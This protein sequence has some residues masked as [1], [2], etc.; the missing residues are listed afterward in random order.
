MAKTAVCLK[1]LKNQ[2]EKTIALATKMRLIDKSLIISRKTDCLLIPLLHYPTETEIEMLKKETSSKVT[3]SELDSLI[4]EEGVFEEKVQP[5]KTLTQALQD[6][7]PKDLLAILPQAF[8]IVGDIV[9]IDIPP[10]LKVH[11][12]LIGRTILETH[13]NIKTV[14][15]KA[16]DISG[17]Y[18]VRDYEFI[19]GEAK[20]STVHREF[21]WVY[22]VDV[23]KAYFSPRLSHEHER[24]AAQVQPGEVAV[25][26]FAGVGPFAVLIGKRQPE[27][28][29]YAVDLNPDAVE[30]LR[31]NVK[32]N[33]VADRVF[34]VCADAREIAS[35]ELCGVADRVIMNLPETAIDFVDAACCAI[36]PSGGIVH[37]YGFV[38][39]PDSVDN[40]VQ[41]FTEAV[42]HNGKTVKALLQA[43]SIRETAPFESQI[44][45]DVQIQ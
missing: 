35:G 34:P 27:A 37:F 13:R 14:L 8:D 9:I 30:L 33:K 4:I 10:L 5:S 41:R 7:L 42:E 26:L 15:A 45:L 36:K 12:G 43:R 20:T 18:R 31:S 16:G 28:R 23:A 11:Q 40:L 1:V 21:G 38:R 3:L 25:D 19:A 44:V 29:V 17:V 39:L 6:Q 32:V 2:G 22:H 24:V